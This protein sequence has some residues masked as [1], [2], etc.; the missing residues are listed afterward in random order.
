MNIY[1]ELVGYVGTALVLLSMMMTSVTKLRWLNMAGSVVSM[2]YAYMCG[3]MPVFVLNLCLAVI[4]GVQL[5]RWYRKN[6]EETV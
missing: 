3:T 6:K 1:L 2:F 4:N 5:V